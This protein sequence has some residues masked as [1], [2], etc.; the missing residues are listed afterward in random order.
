MTEPLL[1]QLLDEAVER[2]H[3]LA[4]QAQA[5]ATAGSD[6]AEEVLGL[7][8]LAE[9][10]GQ[11]LHVDVEQA[12]E[13]LQGA[14]ARITEAVD[15]AVA[16]LESIPG[17]AAQSAANLQ[18]MFEALREQVLRLDSSRQALLAGLEASAEALDQDATDLQESVQAYIAR[19]QEAWRQPMIGMRGLARSAHELRFHADDRVSLVKKDIGLLG[20][21]A[22]EQCD[23]FVDGTVRG[24]QTIADQLATTLDEALGRHNGLMAE[25]RADTLDETPAGVADPNWVDTALEPLKNELAV[26]DPVASQVEEALFAPLGAIATTGERGEQQLEAVAQSLAKVLGR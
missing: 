26:L 11:G 6:V 4:T 25:L 8:Q 17:R 22:L 21:V 5:S 9:S 7:A 10:E 19:V 16:A 15:R 18:S 13:A 1:N 2:C 14:G 12:I 20:Q 24:A 3:E 23:T